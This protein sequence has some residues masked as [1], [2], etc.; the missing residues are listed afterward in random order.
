MIWLI[1][2]WGI[3]C[4]LPIE[5][6]EECEPEP[7]EHEEIMCPGIDSMKDKCFWQCDEVRCPGLSPEEVA[8]ICSNGLACASFTLILTVIGHSRT[9]RAG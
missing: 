3:L 8:F 2:L 6:T 4:R 7:G 1:S 9:S 5:V